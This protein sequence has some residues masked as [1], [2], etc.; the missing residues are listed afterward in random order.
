LRWP[1][2][3]PGT[4]DIDS[5]LSLWCCIAMI[6]KAQPNRSA[7]HTATAAALTELM[8]EAFRL[9]GRLLAAGDDLVAPIGLTSARWQVIGAIA[10]AGQA[11][12]VAHIARNMGLT[13]QS[14][15]RVVNGLEEDGLIAFSPN[16]HHQ[17]AKLVALTPKGRK[18]FDSAHALQ[19]AWANELSRGMKQ[20]AVTDALETMRNLRI[21]LEQSVRMTG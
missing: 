12:P 17:R 18:T 21:R 20:G 9:N 16:P 13:R 4:I 7:H 15:Q 6:D 5:L 3:L 1:H 8:L 14:V 19:I 10:L 2:Q 11:L